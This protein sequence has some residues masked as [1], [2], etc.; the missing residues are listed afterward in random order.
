[1]NDSFD[2]VED[3]IREIQLGNLVIVMDSKD[4]EY[5]GDFIGAAS[6]ATP[7]T[8]NFLTKHARGAYVAVFMP[9][10]L[11]DK[12]DIPPMGG[13]VNDSFNQTKFRL[14]VDAKKAVSGS[15]AHDRAL[16]VNLLGDA[17]SKPSDFVRPGHVVPIEAHEKGLGGRQGHTEAGVELVKLAGIDPPAAVDLE[18]LDDDGNMA[19]E[20]KL[21][22]LSERFNIRI[23]RLEDI[24]EYSGSL[25]KRSGASSKVVMIG[26]K[27]V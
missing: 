26:S 27:S 12:L 11:C 5:E 6:R 2:N 1:M 17:Q 4:R 19:H 24:V 13:R 22:E 23:I 3:A 20:E 18:I 16:T 25:R 21:F 8:I 7:E 9:F 14:A 15:S 10:G